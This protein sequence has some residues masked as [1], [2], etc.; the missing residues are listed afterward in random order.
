MKPMELKAGQDS[1]P[2]RAGIRVRTQLKVRPSNF[3]QQ[4][5]ICKEDCNNHSISFSEICKEDC[6]R[7]ICGN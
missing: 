7:E 5:E 6:Q 4:C 2:A 3:Y 1:D